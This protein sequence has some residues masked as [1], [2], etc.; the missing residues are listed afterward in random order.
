MIATGSEDTTDIP[1]PSSFTRALIYSLKELARAK[2]PFTSAD[3]ASEIQKAPGF[4]RT[5]EPI[6]SSLEDRIPKGLISFYPM[7]TGKNDNWQSIP[8]EN[9][10]SPISPI[11]GCA[12]RVLTLHFYISD[13]P[14]L[15]SIE[16]L[17]D[18]FNRGS[19]LEKMGVQNIRWGGLEP[20]A[21]YKS[22]KAF[23][24]GLHRR[25][26]SHNVEMQASSPGSPP[27]LEPAR[28]GEDAWP[29]LNL[30][31][32]QHQEGQVISTDSMSSAVS[33]APSDSAIYSL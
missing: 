3:L 2:R 5:Q 10:A 27:P 4:P 17:G 32:P 22:V 24:D 7:G 21:F 11:L 8:D 15:E 14:S 28:P 29:Q 20:H 1:G 12:K 23:K 33:L 26:K 16:E 13:M 6:L 25:R 30:R 31:P 19:A 9:Q 18:L